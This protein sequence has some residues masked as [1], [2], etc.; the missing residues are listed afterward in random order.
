MFVWALVFLLIAVA[1]VLSQQ[2]LFITFLFL[3]IACVGGRIAWR[4][5][6]LP[7][8]TL[9]DEELCISGVFVGYKHVRWQ[10]IKAVEQDEDWLRIIGREWIGSTQINLN[11][12]VQI[13]R[14]EFINLVRQHVDGASAST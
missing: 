9:T 6:A 13:E 4:R 2:S 11:H 5:V 3:A 14:D 1:Q 10:D 8:Y 7:L 12:L